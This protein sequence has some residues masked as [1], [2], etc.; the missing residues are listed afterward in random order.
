MQ[1]SNN[2]GKMAKIINFFKERKKLKENIS[3][4]DILYSQFA[5]WIERNENP[6]KFPEKDRSLKNIIGQVSLE[7]VKEYFTKILENLNGEAKYYKAAKQ[8][9]GKPRNE[10]LN[11]SNKAYIEFLNEKNPV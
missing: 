2:V 10:F 9:I 4:E 1:N 5:M 6:E 7:E 11:Y 8:I 3:K